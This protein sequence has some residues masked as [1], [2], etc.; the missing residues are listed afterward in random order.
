M[1]NYAGNV[2]IPQQQPQNIG[3]TVGAVQTGTQSL[4]FTN[5]GQNIMPQ[6]YQ[7]EA[8]LYSN[9]YA[10][11][12]QTGAGQAAGMG[13]AAAGNQ[14][15]LGGNLAGWGQSILPY[16]QP[17]MQSAF[18]PQQQLYNYMQNQNLQQ[19]NVENAMAGVAA[20]PY[21]A[22][23]ADQSNQLFN[24]NWQNQQL[25]R[26][27]QG[28][29]GLGALGQAATGAE[30]AGTGMQ[31]GAAPQWLQSAMYPYATAQQI[32][33]DQNQA[34]ASLLGIAGSAQAP[35]QQSIMDYLTLLQAQTGAQQVFANQ[36]AQ[37]GLQQAQLEQGA[38]NQ[39]GTGLGSAVGWLSGGGPQTL[40]SNVKSGYNWLTS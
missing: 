33:G 32:G 1:Q 30:T 21:G 7:T 38:W 26:Q 27:L 29:Q 36:P 11:Q 40:A 25:A 18:D 6:A 22:G 34:I 16:S 35:T 13:Q 17:L 15:N 31:A 12:F 28:I 10:G 39:L 37:L 23:V 5:V 14:F 4:P 24:I 9:P 20:T 3:P 8:N 2:P 19:A